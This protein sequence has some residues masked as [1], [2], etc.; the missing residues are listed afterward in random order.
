[1]IF[2]NF[3]YIP[4]KLDIV[5]IG[6]GISFNDFDWTSVSELKGYNLAVCPEDF[7]YDARI[8]KKFGCHIK[9]GGFVI[10]VVCPLSFG[11]NE[12]LYEDY[13]SE[14]YVGLL[15]PEDV[16]ISMIKYFLYSKIHF[17][18]P[19]HTM[20]RKIVPYIKVK[21]KVLISGKIKEERQVIKTIRGWIHDSPGLTNLEDP[22]QARKFKDVFDEKKSG[23]RCIIDNC[24][25]QNLRPVILIPP[26]S[27]ELFNKISLEFLNAFMYDN[28]KGEVER[29]IPL[30][31]YLRDEELKSDSNYS[32]GIYLNDSAKKVF[33]NK[34]VHDIWLYMNTAK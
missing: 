12:Y 11:K 34:V 18:Y 10:I 16:D 32:N 17:L 22:G 14:K 19:L 20:M 6:S 24:I 25:L 8:I 26:M 31:D 15:P 23:L 21:I 4:D 33:T 28:I 13:F 1:M 7:R 3:K 5:N 9:K 2:D 29:G 30:L 27:D